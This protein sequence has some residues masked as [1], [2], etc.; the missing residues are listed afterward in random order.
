MATLSN[1][2]E[3]NMGKQEI[4]KSFNKTNWEEWWSIKQNN[5]E[6]LHDAIVNNNIKTV[7]SLLQDKKNAISGT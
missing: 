4:Q 3:G 5:N 1:Y 7:K 2:E 6:K